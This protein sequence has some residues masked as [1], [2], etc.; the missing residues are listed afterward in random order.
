M[1]E[2]ENDIYELF[3]SAVDEYSDMVTRICVLMLGNMIDAQDAYLSAFE[4]LFITL[5]KGRRPDDIKKWLAKVAYNECKSVLR[6]MLRH[7]QVSM[8]DVTEPFKKQEELE[9]VELLFT[10]PENYR[11][12]LY[13]YYNEGYTVAEIARITGKRENTVRSTLKRARDKLRGAYEEYEG[14][15]EP[16][17]EG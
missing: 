11:N 8:P 17:Y 10:L 5:K 3:D 13:L 15:G 4:K 1:D 6:F 14:K 12:M 2:N 9:L 7:R 16:A